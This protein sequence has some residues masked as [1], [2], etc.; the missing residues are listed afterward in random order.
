MKLQKKICMLGSFG[1]GKTSLVS[2]FVHSIFS[3][4][5]LTTIGVRIDRKD[6]EIGEC[7]LTLILWDL[8]G[9]DQFERIRSS[10]L[11]GMSAYIL[12]IDGCRRETLGKALAI[13]KH[14]PQQ[15]D[16]VPFLCVINKSDLR[17]R[18][19]VTEADIEQLRD[20]GWEVL[21][22]TATE[23]ESVHTIFQSLAARLLESSAD[24][25]IA[26]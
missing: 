4:D 26:V 12:V 25:S 15:M 6:I 5:Y 14:H 13:Q 3:E 2:Q 19:E 17:D 18:W 21:T 8:A 9:E 23:S 11:K 10:Y 22:S 20:L 7:D 16:D 24:R 1:V